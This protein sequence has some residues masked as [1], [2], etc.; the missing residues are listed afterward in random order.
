MPANIEEIAGGRYAM[1]SA[2]EVPWHKLGTATDGALTAEE[3]AKLAYLADWN[4]RKVDIQTFRVTDDP[5][6]HMRESGI[7]IPG[8]KATVRTNPVTGEVQT[9]GVVGERYKV[10]Q[11]EE[12]FAVLDAIV[13]E[14][15]AHF[16]TAG[17]LGNGERVFMSMKMPDGIT[18]AGED[19]HDVYLLATN[20]HDGT[21]SFTVAVT[22]VRV[23]CQNTLT[24]ALRG[25]KQSWSLRHTRSVQGRIQ[26]ARESLQLTFAYMDSFE[27]ELKALLDRP[28]SNSEFNMFTEDMLPDTKS[29]H[30]G[31]QDRVK[32]QRALMAGLFN[33]SPTN[34]FGRNTRYAAYNAATEY[35]DWLM[36]VKGAD[37][38]GTRRAIRAMSTPTV[39]AFKSNALMLL[40]S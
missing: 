24:M 33:F 7:V 17:A 16:E 2:R 10:I 35:A 15:G 27:A 3:A 28:M 26:E 11:N 9:L 37:P 21:S 22:P 12:A 38:D 4:V 40:R 32:G 30:G 29:K 34:R 36:P 19:R 31:W 23:V 13:D 8:R 20:S 25:T 1:V 5:N 18:V 14:G 39:Q 6:L